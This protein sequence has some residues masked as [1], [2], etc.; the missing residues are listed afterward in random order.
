MDHALDSASIDRMP[1]I[2]AN[3]LCCLAAA[4]G[5]EQHL[6]VERDGELFLV[7]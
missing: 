6:L 2:S 7:H 3:V 4:L 1:G 5:E